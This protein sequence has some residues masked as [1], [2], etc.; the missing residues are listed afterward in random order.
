[1]GLTH[2]GNTSL[3]E[4]RF[5]VWKD[6]LL[7]TERYS[8]FE[9]HKHRRSKADMLVGRRPKEKAL[10]KEKHGYFIGRYI[11]TSLED[12]NVPP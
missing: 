10:L 11:G 3:I 5:R 8:S 2:N 12:I 7:E 1:M 6:S 9:G 4:N